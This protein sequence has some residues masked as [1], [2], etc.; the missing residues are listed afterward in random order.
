[1]SQL[2][3]FFGNAWAQDKREITIIFVLCSIALLV[4]NSRLMAF[5]FSGVVAYLYFWK[6]LLKEKYVSAVS[7]HIKLSDL[8]GGNI[9]SGSPAH[10][11]SEAVFAQMDKND[12]KNYLGMR[13]LNAKDGKHYEIIIQRADGETPLD[14]LHRAREELKALKAQLGKA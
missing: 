10:I 7:G 4:G 3:V 14:Q 9:P 8:M 2:K 12:A 13:L 11:L 5:V 6:I 1:V